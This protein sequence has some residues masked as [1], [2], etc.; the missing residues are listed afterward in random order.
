[1]GNLFGRSSTRFLVVTLIP[2]VLFALFLATLLAAGAPSRVPSLAT[3]VQVLR[4]VGVREAAVLFFLVL[5]AAVA[6]HPVQYPMIQ[7]LEGYWDSVPGGARLSEWATLR[8]AARW[9]QLRAVV[10][11]TVPEDRATFRA[12]ASASVRLRWLPSDERMLLP[13][14]LGNTLRA[15]E[16]RAG[17]RYGLRIGVIM[18]RLGPLLQ[19]QVRRQLEDRRNQLDAAARLCAVSLL[20]TVAGVALLL[21][22]GRWLLIPASTFA[23]A[24]ACYRA[25][26]AAAAGF[27]TDLAAAVDLHHRDLWTALA[28][29]PPRDLREEQRRAATLGKH[30]DGGDLSPEQVREIVWQDPP[31]PPLFGPLPPPP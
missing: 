21:P 22:T 29:R 1:M 27:C 10:A 16:E 28:L 17:R 7:L 31:L 30:L 3:A 14:S 20:A 26:C 24:W 9:E 15:G 18:P 11:N 23:F 2:N 6:L 25:A 12:L 5:V 13:T 19:P 4:D 8:H